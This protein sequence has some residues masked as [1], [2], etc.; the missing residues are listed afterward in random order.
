VAGP[1]TSSGQADRRKTRVPLEAGS[2]SP[3]CPEVSRRERSA[4]ECAL[5]RRAL[6]VIFAWQASIHTSTMR[7][8]AVSPAAI[9]WD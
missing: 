6:A 4:D 9:L 3:A 1:S 5:S 7:N 8:R 2:S